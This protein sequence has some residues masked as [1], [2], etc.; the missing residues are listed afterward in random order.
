MLD[1]WV[2]LYVA[3]LNSDPLC[4]NV[5]NVGYCLPRKVLVCIL[6]PPTPPPVHKVSENKTEFSCTVKIISGH[7]VHQNHCR[8]A[9]ENSV[10]P[11]MSSVL[12]ISILSLPP[13]PP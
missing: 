13:P 4:P 8:G 2:H 10:A 12:C 1:V 11:V 5:C 9:A 7:G 6:I 3:Q